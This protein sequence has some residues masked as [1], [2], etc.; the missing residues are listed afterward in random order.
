MASIFISPVSQRLIKSSLRC[1]NPYHSSSNLVLSNFTLGKFNESQPLICK[2]FRSLPRFPSIACHSSSPASSSSS[3][4]NRSISDDVS[5]GQILKVNESWTHIFLSS[6]VLMLVLLAFMSQWGCGLSF[7]LLCASAG[8]LPNFK[9]LALYVCA[10]APLVRGIGCTINDI[11]DRDIDIWVKRT[12]HRPLAS[13]ELTLFEG[14]CFLGFQLLL[15]LG[16]GILTQLDM[17][18]W[19]LW[20]IFLFLCFTYPLMKRLTYWPQAYLGLTLGWESLLGWQ[21]VKGNLDLAIL[22]PLYCSIMFELMVHDTIYAHQDKEDD[23]K[24]GVKSTALLFGD[25]TKKWIIGF[26]TACIVCFALAGFNAKI[27]W[28]YYIFLAAASRILAWQILTVDLSSPDD[29]NSK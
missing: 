2:N 27:G 13:G 28:P 14:L 15:L 8:H 16:F 21:A 6:F 29:C 23:L 3:K 10:A 18:S 4:E 1:P 11:F 25:S 12:K 7:G 5:K 20:A 9:E 24:A 17:F 26:G 22:L 19:T